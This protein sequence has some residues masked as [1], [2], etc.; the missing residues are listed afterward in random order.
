MSM[1]VDLKGN[2]KNKNKKAPLGFDAGHKCLTDELNYLKYRS[3]KNRSLN[4]LLL[5]YNCPFQSYL[6]PTAL[7]GVFHEGHRKK[8]EIYRGLSYWIRNEFFVVFSLN[9][10]IETFRLEDEDDYEER[11][12]L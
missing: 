10:G 1:K 7:S 2:L 5:L 4:E 11:F 9:K 12:M 8:K 6:H 3:S